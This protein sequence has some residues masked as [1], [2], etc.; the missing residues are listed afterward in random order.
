M[1]YFDSDYLEG[2]APEIL[3]ALQKSNFDQTPGYGKDSY[4]ESAKEKIKD[5][6][7]KNIDLLMAVWNELYPD[8]PLKIKEKI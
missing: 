2:C 6:Y 4:C 3:E 7:D 8:I 1:K 5:W